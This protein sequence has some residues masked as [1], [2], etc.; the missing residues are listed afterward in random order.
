MGDIRVAVKEGTSLVLDNDKCFHR[1]R[2]LWGNGS[3]KMIA[4]NLLRHDAVHPLDARHVVEQ[5]LREIVDD[6]GVIGNEWLVHLLQ[7]Y[8]VGDQ[9]YIER[10]MDQ[11]RKCKMAQSE[12]VKVSSAQLQSNGYNQ[13]QVHHVHMA[14]GS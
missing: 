9:R 13:Q 12:T 6:D 5:S 8:V 11:Q 1:V 7:A 14:R 2:E 4:F 10:A 3:R